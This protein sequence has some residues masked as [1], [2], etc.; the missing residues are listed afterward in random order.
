VRLL[1][2]KGADPN[3]VVGYGLT[4]GSDEL[5]RVIGS[6]EGAGVRIDARGPRVVRAVQ[7][8]DLAALR[9]L[10]ENG[11][12]RDVTDAAGQTPLHLA[13]LRRIAAHSSDMLESL[14][15]R[16]ATVTASAGGGVTPLHQAVHGGSLEAFRLLIDHRADPTLKDD[17][18]K[19]P[20]D[21]AG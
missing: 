11:A 12:T 2:G 15:A 3:E 14:R 5:D 21:D 10:L 13:A 20:I 9:R 6:L 19:T 4:T 18:G 1:L 17:A 16:G 7:K 8:D